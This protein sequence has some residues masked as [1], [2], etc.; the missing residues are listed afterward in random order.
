MELTL[1]CGHSVSEIES[2]DDGESYCRACAI[3]QAIDVDVDGSRAGH[4]DE[5]EH[6][7]AEVIVLALPQ[8][9]H[10][11]RAD[12]PGVRGCWAISKRTNEP[13]GSPAAHGGEFCAAH[14]GLG[15]AADP[16]RYVPLAHQARKRN[17]EIRATM[18]H[19]IGDI[20]RTSP[21]QVLRAA[22]IAQAEPLVGRAVNAALSS[23]VP[24]DRAGKLALEL[25]REVDPA[26]KAEVSL[27]ASMPQSEEQVDAMIEDG[28]LMHLLRSGAFSNPA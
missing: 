11:V 12:R 3:D 19:L 20:G 26:V 5:A 25:I 23:E 21:R 6:V 22:V 4:S 28:S 16:Q 9:K 8:P 7:G 15:I 2:G 1:S 14:S 13:C 10:S 27:S 17:L 18:R 24:D